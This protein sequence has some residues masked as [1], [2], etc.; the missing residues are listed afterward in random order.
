[1]NQ[2][3]LTSV[4]EL[5]IIVLLIGIGKSNAFTIG[6]E[7]KLILTQAFNFLRGEKIVIDQVTFDDFGYYQE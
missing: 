1:M 4:N 3:P 7:L 5:L 2:K 6:C